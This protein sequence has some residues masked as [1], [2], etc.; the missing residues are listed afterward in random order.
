MSWSLI[1]AAP[2]SGED[3]HRKKRDIDARISALQSKITHAKTQEGV[4]TKQISAVS[5]KIVALQD[6]VDAA[7]DQ[8]N[9]L[10]AQLAAS[11]QEASIV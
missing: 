3:I 2:A 9:T 4:L 8:L 10:E 6:D 1:V 7:Q 11:Q 5:D